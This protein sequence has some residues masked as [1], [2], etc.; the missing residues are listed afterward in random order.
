MTTKAFVCRFQACSASY[1][2]R[3]HLR[4]H[5]AQH[6]RRQPLRCSVCDREFG[7]S[8]TLRRHMQ[9][10]HG[11]SQP[12]PRPKY[13]CTHCRNSKSR[14]EGGP[15]C[16]ACLRR[17]ICC[18]LEPRAT[19]QQGGPP[20]Y[21]TG[22]LPT[23][24][25]DDLAQRKAG[26]SEKQ[27]HY[28][29]LYFRLFHP[30]WPFLHRASFNDCRETPLLIQSMVVIGLWVSEEPNARAAAIDLHNVLSS[31]IH[32]QKD[33]W[34]ASTLVDPDSTCPWPISMYQAILLHIIFA[35][36][37]KGNGTLGLDLKPSLAPA[38]A[39]LLG[40]LVASCKK[41]G[42]LYYPNMLTRYCRDSPAVYIWV[43]IE[44]IKRFGLALFK[45]SRAFN[46]P[47][48]Q[49]VEE[50]D[51]TARAGERLLVRDLKFPLPMNT[52]LW[53][54]A[55]RADYASA[56]TEDAF[57]HSVDEHLEEEWVSR[58]AIALGLLE[59]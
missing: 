37:Y 6:S 24:L 10:T 7:R 35:L 45:V 5:E 54:T 18:S 20:H 12:A 57:R 23:P 19:E 28:L 1:Q 50:F 32:Q 44:E 4:R 42:M 21:L 17:G 15:P 22:S 55:S 38:E 13:A 48:K 26:R 27:R 51:I 41:L 11:V 49:G 52:P 8:D 53:N 14:C 36:L 25:H 31:A 40:R 3:E 43:S 2:R 58:S 16:S 9:K 34:D 47:A 39:D 56:I 29:D 59:S 46:R 30:Y 33:A